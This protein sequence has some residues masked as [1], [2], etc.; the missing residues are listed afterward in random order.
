MASPTKR[1]KKRPNSAPLPYSNVK[2]RELDLLYPQSK[3]KRAIDT[4]ESISRAIDSHIQTTREYIGWRKI[5]DDS[6]KLKQQLSQIEAKNPI[7]PLIGVLIGEVLHNLRSSLD[8]IAAAGVRAGNA[9]VDENIAFPIRRTEDKFHKSFPRLLAGSPPE[10]VS[11]IESFEAHGESTDQRFFNL[12]ELNNQDKHEAIVVAQQILYTTTQISNKMI[13]TVGKGL[14]LPLH[15]GK[16]PIGQA[17]SKTY[18]NHHVVFGDN[19]VLS[20]KVITANLAALNERVS[21]VVEKCK[22]FRY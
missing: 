4:T 6:K 20:G 10:F 21:E 11:L 7:D 3:L 16:P 14:G 18:M 22:E 17:I 9:P 19:R 15:Q 1:K 2:R 8:H 12:W 13:P 5:E